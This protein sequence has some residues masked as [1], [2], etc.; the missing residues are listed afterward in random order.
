MCMT[1]HCWICIV[2]KYLQNDRFLDELHVPIELNNLPISFQ[3][4]IP[5]TMAQ[6]MILEIMILH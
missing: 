6:N 2:I 5:E 3:M 4:K 1:G